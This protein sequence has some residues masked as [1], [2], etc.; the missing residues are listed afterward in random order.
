MC[1]KA[2][3]DIESTLF[4]GGQGTATIFTGVDASSLY[5]IQ[6]DLTSIGYNISDDGN[7]GPIDLPFNFSL[8]N[9]S[10]DQAWMFSNGVL[11]F[12][13]P[14]T[15]FCCVGQDLSSTVS[16]SYDYKIFPLW[17]DLIGGQGTFFSKETENSM[18]FGWYNIRE[19]GR[20]NL[21]S[22]EVELFNTNDIE[23][24]YDNVNVTGHAVTIGLTGELSQ[25][26]YYQLFYGV[27]PQVY[28]TTIRVQISVDPCVLDPLFATTC[29]GYQQA[30]TTLQCAS[31]PLYDY[32]CAGYAEAFAASIAQEQIDD[33][34]AVEDMPQENVLN[35]FSSQ[36][37][38]T[39]AAGMTGDSTSTFNEVRTDVGGI[40]LSSTGELVIEN[41]IPDI[42]RD[43]S[44]DSQEKE[45]KTT[46][47][48]TLAIARKA[49]EETEKAAI[50]IVNNSI[51]QSASLYANPLDGIGINQDLMRYI[52]S[53][54]STSLSLSNQIN[55]S[56][57][58][59]LNLNNSQRKYELENKKID[60]TSIY[61]PDVIKSDTDKQ[62]QKELLD[63]ALKPRI[64]QQEKSEELE[65]AVN[66][67]TED[68]EAS[69]TIKIESIAIIN[70][71]FDL[72]LTSSLKDVSFYQTKKIYDN[73][74]P[75]DNERLLRRLNSRNDFL[76]K[77]M[78]D[79][80]YR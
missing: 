12:S 56:G 78:V 58:S 64:I 69:G 21:N 9:Q 8:F 44:I 74:K 79:Q 65:E 50:A 68:N 39:T 4:A 30:F 57:P 33:L 54:D 13:T 15:S 19:Y 55:T 7:S 1:F 66:R 27:N 3:A 31:N 59:I 60:V 41:E 34:I 37:E 25:G 45:K 73:Q 71:G 77:E 62:R 61:I 32:T 36:T 6:N 40:S 76:H 24:R 38:P 48:D 2:R 18:I 47:I 11:G 10:F 35:S 53:Q 70:P 28:N 17:T 43:I 20:N 51:E 22:F 23:F 29:P 42:I 16:D 52:S 49:I 75:V 63:F 5:N 14:T 46:D 80:Q 26:E 67:K 72:Y